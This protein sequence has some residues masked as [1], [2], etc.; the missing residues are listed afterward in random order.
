MAWWQYV[1]IGLGIYF[2]IGA[3]GCFYLFAVF[4]Y[5]KYVKRFPPDPKESLGHFIA[6]L[7]IPLWP[8]WVWVGIQS[9]RDRFR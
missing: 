8:F 9:L 6:W 3:A 2:G 5:E 4:G 7:T 1:L